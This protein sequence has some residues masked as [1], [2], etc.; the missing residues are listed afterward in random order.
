VSAESDHA[1]AEE[2]RIGPTQTG[3]MSADSR[4]SS[5][6]IVLTAFSLVLTAISVAAA[7]IALSISRDA[8][9][10]SHLQA[11]ISEQGVLPIIEVRYS[12]LGSHIHP[13]REILTVA[14]RGAALRHFA[15]I[16]WV[17]LDVRY[18]KQ[19]GESRLIRHTFIPLDEYFD[20]GPQVDDGR[21]V[22]ARRWAPDNA[23]LLDRLEGKLLRTTLLTNPS[24]TVTIIPCRFAAVGYTDQ[25][26]K[27]HLDV[28][29]EES[30]VPE[31]I[32]RQLFD[33]SRMLRLRG[34][35]SIRTLSARAVLQIAE[36][37]PV[38]PGSQSD[39]YFYDVLRYFLR[40]SQ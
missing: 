17:F 3:Q 7:I 22:L 10:T 16:P 1:V 38:S 40:S 32:G 15:V 33:F 36:H 2:K 8:N 26:G 19:T 18:E 4:P 30:L 37:A 11:R 5:W 28:F 12:V 9:R 23:L 6:H 21:G 39:C 24:E 31:G 25:L 13:R 14:N 35:M 34:R 27:D 20:T 29:Q